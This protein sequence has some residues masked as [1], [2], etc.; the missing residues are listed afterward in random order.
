MDDL[1]LNSGNPIL[2]MTNS[3][4]ETQLFPSTGKYYI[5][6]WLM[7]NISYGRC[8]EWDF[9]NCFRYEIVSTMLEV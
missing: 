6:F 2:S 7:L 3:S 4:F 1:A 5:V 9:R 8:G